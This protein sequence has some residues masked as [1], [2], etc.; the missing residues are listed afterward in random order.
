MLVH[1]LAS[2]IVPTNVPS[3]TRLLQVSHFSDPSVDPCMIPSFDQSNI[4]SCTSHSISS[5]TNP[6]TIHDLD[7]SSIPSC[8]SYSSSPSRNPS[9]DPIGDPNRTPK[10]D[11][12]SIL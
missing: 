3:G 9:R 12:L 11:L 10:F 6:N 2:A 8:G 5:S 1:S 7:P 4:P